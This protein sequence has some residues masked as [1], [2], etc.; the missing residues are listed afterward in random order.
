M[1]MDYMPGDDYRY[2]AHPANPM[3]SSAEKEDLHREAGKAVARLH[4]ITRRAESP[5]ASNRRVVDALDTLERV[6]RNTSCRVTP[7]LI[8][9]CREIARGEGALSRS[10]DAQRIGDGDLHF[11]RAGSGW[12]L[13]FIC[14]L[15]YTGFGDPDFDLAPMLCYPD[16]LWD[17]KEPLTLG[18]LKGKPVNAFFEGYEEVAPID[19][20]RVREVAVY[21]HLCLKCATAREAYGADQ[22][23][24][25][26]DRE[27]AIYLRLL[28]AIQARG[29][30]PAS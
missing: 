12:K 26:E 7:R 3:T 25:I 23:E 24:G 18:A 15:E 2:L 4:Q 21:A 6:V 19:Y 28:E 17:L 1:V 22:R 30:V 14:D 10:L 27:P 11:T 20:D 5:D 9:E 29:H 13:S 8:D 16:F